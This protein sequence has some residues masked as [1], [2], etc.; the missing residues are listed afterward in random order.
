VGKSALDTAPS[1]LTE[2]PEDCLNSPRTP[3]E[4]RR[5]QSAPSKMCGF[6]DRAIET[7]YERDEGTDK[8]RRLSAKELWKHLEPCSPSTTATSTDVLSKLKHP[9]DDNISTAASADEQYEM[10]W[11]QRPVQRAEESAQPGRVHTSATNV[12]RSVST[13]VS[14]PKK[15]WD[16]IRAENLG[17]YNAS[18]QSLATERLNRWRERSNEEKSSASSE[19]LSKCADRVPIL[20]GRERDANGDTTIIYRI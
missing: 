14:D 9:F 4:V 17:R 19:K 5:T 16:T 7:I 20:R 13:P 10:L 15:V 12:R 11:V 6:E 3:L 2:T 18:G 1:E 8:K